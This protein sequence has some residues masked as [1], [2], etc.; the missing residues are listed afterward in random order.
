MRQ[1]K[2]LVITSSV[3]IG[4][5]HRLTSS[6]N[7]FDHTSET[8][9]DTT[10]LCPEREYLRFVLACQDT[11]RDLHLTRKQIQGIV[12]PEHSAIFAAQIAILEDESFIRDLRLIIEQQRIS[13]EDA[14]RQTLQQYEQI[15]LSMQRETF[16]QRIFD[17]RDVWSRVFSY[18]STGSGL[19][20]VNLR[21]PAIIVAND[22][23]PSQFANLP[24]QFVQGLVTHQDSITSH[25]AILAKA[26]NMPYITGIEGQHEITDGDLLV[27]DGER[28]ILY[29]NPPPDITLSYHN[30]SRQNMPKNAQSSDTFGQ[31]GDTTSVLTQCGQKIILRT[32]VCLLPEIAGTILS[33]AEG[34]GLL[35]T[36]FLYLNRAQI[37]TEEEQ[38]QFYSAV[39]RQIAPHPVT[40]R[41][42]D[43]G[44]DKRLEYLKLA[45]EDNPQ[46]GYRGVRIQLEHRELLWPQLLALLRASADGAVRI[47][48]P[49]LSTHEELLAMLALVDQARTEISRRG[50]A[51]AACVPI[52][53]MIETPAAALMSEHLT[54]LVDFLSIGSND[55]SQFVMA[56][57]RNHPGLQYLLHPL[58][59]ALL[60]LI[61][62]V[63]NTAHKFTRP[64]SICGEMA[65]NPTCIPL[66]LGLGLRELSVPP[67][68]ISNVKGLLQQISIDQC[69]LLAQQALSLPSAH[70]I[71]LLFI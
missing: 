22:I 14:L 9:V 67:V 62:S 40:F 59:P 61:A 58:Q 65:H 64:I 35:R 27:I 7:A 3:A 70:D 45:P 21:S 29:L 10:S 39:A 43:V 56:A 16:R 20:S 66:L 42:I 71:S 15:F 6:Y 53:I 13:A 68:Q 23:L 26:M 31:F 38:Y 57:D 24:F 47:M 51:Q 8:I 2:G 34:I 4:I 54:P 48:F 32:N 28:G 44:G 49:M 19:T 60:H 36:E 52:G 30:T 41:S 12:G 33:G 46:M 50:Q 18:L 69:T 11:M 25:T 63:V 37:P 17:L 55:L 1:Y 5:A